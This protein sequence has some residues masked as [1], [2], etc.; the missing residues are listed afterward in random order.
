MSAPAGRQPVLV[1]APE[2]AGADR[3]PPVGSG[4]EALTP[5]EL[6]VVALVTLGATNQQA[7]RRLRLSP[8]T[9]N[10]HLRHVFTKLGVTSRVEL[11][12]VAVVREQHSS[13]HRPPG[14]PPARGLVPVPST[15]PRTGRASIGP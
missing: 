9:V 15:P 6:E 2:E 11:T 7:A 13:P 3:P 1:L 14:S 5:R 8:H 4:W 12:R 10:A